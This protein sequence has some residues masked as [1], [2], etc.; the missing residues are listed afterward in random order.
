M[1]TRDKTPM[2]KNVTEYLRDKWVA[3]FFS[4]MTVVLLFVSA[5]P[6]QNTTILSG[7][8]LAPASLIGEITKDTV[9][10]QEFFAEENNLTTIGL[11]F[12]TYIRDN[13]STINI[14]LSHESGLQPI[15]DT[16]VD[17][18]T[19]IDNTLRSFS[20]P[21]QASSLGKKYTL[22]V[23][24]PDANTGNGVT[25]WTQPRYPSDGIRLF[26][27]G[28]DVTNSQLTLQTGYATD[29]FSAIIR[30]AA[31]FFALITIIFWFS[32]LDKAFLRGIRYINKELGT[33]LFF[34]VS[35]ILI[36]V[37]AFYRIPSLT[38]RAEPWAETAVLYING[39]V[40]YGFF[41]SLKGL[42][43]G[44][45]PFFQ[46]LLSSIIVSL[47]GINANLVV[48][49]QIVALCFVALFCSSINLKIFR[50]LIDNDVVRFFLSILIGIGTYA[51][52]ELF[53]YIN[54]VYFGIVFWLFSVVVLNHPQ[55]RGFTVSFWFLWVILLLTAVSK[56]QFILFLPII[57]V[58]IGYSLWRRNIINSI[59]YLLVALALSVQIVVC[60]SSM[61]SHPHL[62]NNP[63][64]LAV[65]NGVRWFCT[66]ILRTLGVS[67][68]PPLWAIVVIAG[69]VCVT[70][71]VLFYRKKYWAGWLGLCCC[72]LATANAVLVGRMW[73]D[74]NIVILP[75][76]RSTF[77]TYIPLLIFWFAVFFSFFEKKMKFLLYLAILLFCAINIKANNVVDYNIL[78]QSE[79]RWK[80][81]YVLSKNE[82]FFIPINPKGWYWRKNSDQVVADKKI[83]SNY[84][85]D[86]SKD[87][88]EVDG[89]K[90]LAIYV[91]RGRLTPRKRTAVAPQL[92]FMDSN[93]K[94]VKN[95]AKLITEPGSEFAY[96]LIGTDVKTTA[97]IR[98][99]DPAYSQPSPILI[100]IVTS[101]L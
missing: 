46:R 93:N 25:I 44:Y 71:L 36:M 52:Y 40:E 77:F 38:W 66:S 80:S 14:K 48:V 58:C 88:P 101:R 19:L 75:I 7:Q 1:L 41:Q 73:F 57:T 100:S 87:F 97:K 95:A 24:S 4:V 90:I 35:F 33:N 64:P 2:V 37:T 23:S 29:S 11:V 45:S 65:Y 85:Y 68:D 20:F 61:S 51:D 10:R 32:H 22:E 83:N 94:V 28:Q 21:A 96:F 56:S 31:I 47:F 43:F 39:V 67:Y 55:A 59:M 26:K 18:S 98:F 17:A 50:L 60:A 84:D 3:A 16:S 78:A 54:F 15:L 74:S 63:L 70:L 81:L 42:D 62:K 89:K 76:K 99:I 5:L 86:I 53:T 72:F 91:N 69:V 6:I 82:S 27:N 92:E 30:V 8:G 13:H 79:S 49:M 34:I 9:L 12:A